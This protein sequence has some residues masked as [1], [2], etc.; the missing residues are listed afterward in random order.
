[1]SINFKGARIYKLSRDVSFAN[2]EEQLAQF[3]FTPWGRQDRA[4][5]CVERERVAS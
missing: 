2:L 4:G 3:A 5:M 1:M